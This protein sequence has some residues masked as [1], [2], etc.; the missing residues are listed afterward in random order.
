MIATCIQ[1]FIKKEQEQDYKVLK[2]IKDT[3]TS[4]YFNYLCASLFLKKKRQL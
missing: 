3:P 2:K 4:N 1:F